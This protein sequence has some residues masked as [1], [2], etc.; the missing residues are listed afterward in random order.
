MYHNDHLLTSHGTPL[1]PIK[2]V[3]KRVKICGVLQVES[4]TAVFVCSKRVR[5]Q[6]AFSILR[7]K[8]S[9]NI[10]IHP[11][12]WLRSFDLNGPVRM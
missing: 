8:I 6:V 11:P 7:K 9:L 4:C 10:N 3:I 1:T 2:E 12:E 5:I